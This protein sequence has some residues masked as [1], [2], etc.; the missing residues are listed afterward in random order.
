MKEFKTIN[1]GLVTDD[2]GT[3]R[4]INDF[5]LSECGIKRFYQISNYQKGFIRSWHG[6]LK[7]S[8]YVYVSKGSFIVAALKLDQFGEIDQEYDDVYNKFV[9]SDNNPRVLYIPPGYVN[10]HMSLTDDGIIMFFSTSTL[11]ESKGDDIRFGGGSDHEVWKVK[12]R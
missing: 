1:G 4:F 8:K 9:L 10:G 5:N 6:H 2:R 12:E 3:L 11:E 7:E